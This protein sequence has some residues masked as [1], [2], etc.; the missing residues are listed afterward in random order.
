MS[1][2]EY[3]S[4]NDS[5]GTEEGSPN[6]ILAGVLGKFAQMCDEKRDVVRVV[7]SLLVGDTSLDSLDVVIPIVLLPVVSDLKQRL[8]RQSQR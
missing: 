8:T 3:I 1:D 6:E 2:S 7:F 4:S 5:R